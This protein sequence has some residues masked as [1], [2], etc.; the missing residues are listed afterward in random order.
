MRTVT[1]TLIIFQII[2]M[3]TLSFAIGYSKLKLPKNILNFESIYVN[4]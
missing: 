2:A 1:M 4:S 3:C